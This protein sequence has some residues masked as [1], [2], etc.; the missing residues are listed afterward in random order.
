MLS[1]D[2]TSHGGSNTQRAHVRALQI[3]GYVLDMTSHAVS[4]IYC[5]DF[6]LHAPFLGVKAS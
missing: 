6:H 5:M 4:H 2:M 1:L 3:P